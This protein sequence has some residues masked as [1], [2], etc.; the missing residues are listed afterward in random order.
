MLAA[1]PGRQDSHPD[2]ENATMN[3]APEVND[4]AA[5]W[6]VWLIYVLIVF[7]IIF[8]IS[9][10]ALYYY[11]VYGLPLNWLAASP[12]TSWLTQYVFPHF[13]F[14]QSSVGHLL[15]AM[16]WPLILAGF[17]IFIWGFGQIYYAKFTGGEAVTGGL[18]RYIRHPQYTGLAVMGIGTS[19]FWSRFIVLIA[20]VSMMFVYG[21]LARNEEHRCLK[22]FGDGYRRYMSKTGRFLPRGWLPELKLPGTIYAALYVLAL[23]LTIGAGWLM[24]LHIIESM[25]TLQIA[26]TRVI[27][28]APMPANRLQDVWK[29]AAPAVDVSKDQ[30]VYV[31]PASWSIPELGVNAST[32]YDHSGADELAHPSMHGNVPDYDGTGFTVLVAGAGYRGRDVSGLEHVISITPDYSL[33]LDVASGDVRIS[34]TLKKG[35]WAEIPVPVY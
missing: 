19:I 4:K 25:N 20:F 29:T 16:S 11:S 17:F 14:H 15:I 7:E 23:C 27:G 24:K 35:R 1:G 28:V 31:L 10:A 32:T 8:M 34:S 22:Q 26:K 13:V 18:Y 9:P 5:R 12:Y 3:D 6:S 21:L 30:I 33:R 2:K